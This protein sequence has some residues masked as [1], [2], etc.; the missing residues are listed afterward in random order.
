MTASDAWRIECFS[1]VLE[2]RNLPNPDVN[3]SLLLARFNVR[4]LE[5]AF[6]HVAL[7]CP[8]AEFSSLAGG[9]GGSP[10]PTLDVAQRA[11]SGTSIAPSADKPPRSPR[12]PPSGSPRG[13]TFAAELPPLA[14]SPPPLDEPSATAAPEAAVLPQPPDAEA[15][16]EAEAQSAEGSQPDTAVQASVVRQAAPLQQAATQDTMPAAALAQAAM[17]ASAPGD[18]VKAAHAQRTASDAASVVTSPSLTSLADAAAGAASAAPNASTIATNPLVASAPADPRGASDESSLSEVAVTSGFRVTG[19]RV[20]S[21]EQAPIPEPAESGV[22]TASSGGSGSRGGGVP[23]APKLQPKLPVGGGDTAA[24]AAGAARSESLGHAEV[25][26]A[27]CASVPLPHPLLS[28]RAA[29][30]PAPATDTPP[31][32]VT[33]TAEAPAAAGAGADTGGS[34]KQ[35]HEEEDGEDAVNAALGQVATGPEGEASPAG[36]AVSI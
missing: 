26:D 24:P 20:Q 3:F 35:A 13:V 2:T 11:A 27:V 18:A 4:N 29:Q 7:R 1:G 5:P 12:L 17:P 9:S 30:P 31:A 19:F 6:L 33:V 8:A 22:S 28:P 14:L 16:A 36:S 25:L 10:R 21:T 23:A 15:E 32:L 34:G